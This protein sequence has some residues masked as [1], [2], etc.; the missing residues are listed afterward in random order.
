MKP[1]SGVPH[2]QRGSSVVTGLV[3]LGL[4]LLPAPSARKDAIGLLTVRG[5]SRATVSEKAG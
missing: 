3:Q 2:R 5:N 1:T 4:A